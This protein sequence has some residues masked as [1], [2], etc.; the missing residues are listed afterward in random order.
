M[1]DMKLVS[2]IYEEYKKDFALLHWVPILGTFYF[3]VY[4]KQYFILRFKN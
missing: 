3:G 4:A 1:E 2:N